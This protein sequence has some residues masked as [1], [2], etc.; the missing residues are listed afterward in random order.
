MKFK[1]LNLQDLQLQHTVDVSP[2]SGGVSGLVKIPV[3]NSRNNFNPGLSLQYSSSAKNSIFGMGWDIGGLSSISVDTKQG[4]PKYDGSDSFT[5]GGSKA[6]VPQLVENGSK[7]KERIEENGNYYIHF[8]RSKK[9]DLNIRFEKWIKKTDRTVHWRSRTKDNIL[10]IYGLDPT[11]K[12]KIYDTKNNNRIYSW[13]LE[14]QYDNLGNCILYYY[15]EEDDANVD[16]KLVF[17]SNRLKNFRNNGFTRRY[18]DKIVYGNTKPLVPDAAIPGTNKWLFELVFDY[19]QLKHRP[20]T[21]TQAEAGSSWDCRPDPYSVYTAGFEIRTYRLCK[22][23]LMYHHF[24]ELSVST[25]LTGIFECDFHEAETGTTLE[26]ISYTG[27]RRD[28]T[29]G[30]YSEKNLP[31]LT[32]NY[33]QPQLGQFFKGITKETNENLPQGFNHKHTKMVD[34]FGEGISGILTESSNNWYFKQ[35]LGNGE[36]SKQEIVISKPTQELKSASLGDFDN[37]GNLELFTLQGKMAGYYEYQRDKEEWSGFKSFENIPQ[38]GPSKLMDINAN[39]LS[40]LLVE[41]D[42]KITCYPFKGKEGFDKPYEFSKPVSN[43]KLYSPFVGNNLANDYFL[44]D[45]TGDGLSDQ[46]RISNGQVIYYPNLGN[47]HF[48]E[49]VIMENAPL[50]DFDNTYDT[51]RIRL[52]DLDGSGTNDI[53]YLGNGEIRYWYNASG[54]KFVNGGTIKGLPYIDNISESTILDLLGQGTPCL[55]WSNSLNNFQQNALQYLKITNGI[56]PR[57]LVSV[58]NGMGNEIQIEY[59]YSGQHYLEAKKSGNPWISKM[60]SHFTVADKKIVFD[61]ITN[62]KHIAQYKYKD[63]FYDSIERSFACFGLVEQYDSSFYENASITHEKDY[64]QP[65]CTKTWM[66]GGIFG[67]DAK[68][69]KQYY[70]ED[71]LQPMLSPVFFEQQDAINSREFAAGYQNM[72]GQVL[73]QEVYATSLEGIVALHPFMV[74]QSAYCI[75]KLQPENKRHKPAFFAFQTELLSINYDKNPADPL[76]CHQLSLNVNAFGDIEKELNIAYARRTTITD[77]LLQQ[78]TDYIKA[79][80]HSFTSIDT[81]DQYQSGILY[82]SKIFHI[83]HLAH[84]SNKIVSFSEAKASFESIVASAIDFDQD[85][86]SGGISVAKL[87]SWN[88]TFFW[89]N[90][91]NA[92][93]ALGQVENKTLVHHK[94]EA[95]FNNNFITNTFEGKVTPAML[96]DASEGGYVQKDGYWWKKTD[97]NIFLD[98]P[99][100]HVLDRIEK[101][102]GRT[103]RYAYDPYFLGATQITDP[104]DNVNRCEIDYNNLNPYR[105]IDINDNVSEV[106]YDPLGVAVVSFFQGSILD[107]HGTLQPYGVNPLNTY[108]KRNDESFN[109]I[110]TN[111]GLYLQKASSFIY[112]DLSCWETD[113]IPVRSINITREN[114]IHDGKGNVDTSDTIQ[115]E[116]NY[117]DGFGR[118]IQVKRKVEDGPAINRLIDGSVEVDISGEPVL[119]HS[120]NRWLASGH[121]VFNNKLKAIRNFEPF[122][123]NT[124]E[125]ESDTVLETFGVSSQLYY[126]AMG[127]VYRKDYPNSTF[128]EVEY[129][130]WQVISFDQNDT[131]DRSLYKVFREVLPGSSPERMALDKS[132]AHKETPTIINIDPLGREIFIN[133]QNNDGTSRKTESKYDILGNIVEITDSRDLKAFEY[134]YDMQ[135]RQLYE[136][137]MDAGEKWNFHNFLDQT[138]HL[139]DSRNIHQRISY[140][141]MERIISV[142]VDGA[143]GLNHITERF[144]YGEDASIM[145]AKERNLRG[146][147]VKH[148]DQAGTQE[149]TLAV[150]GGTSSKTERRL[151]NN[152]ASEANWNDPL[153]VALAPDIYRTEITYDARA[154]IVEQ[155]LPDQTTRK[156]IY[157]EGDSVQKILVS[158]A[159]GVLTDEEIMKD[160]SYDAKGLRQNVLLGN[161]IKTTY[162]Y[163][164]ESFRMKRLLTRSTGGS[165]RTY[166]DINYT[167]D[168]VGNLVHLVDEAQQPA[169][170]APGVIEG[171]NTS[172]HS[173]FTYDAL[174]QLK[175]ASGRVHQ[176]LLKNDYI[177]RSHESGAPANWAKGS[178]HIALNNGASVERYTRNYTYDES[179]N[180]LSIQHSGATHNW[181]R[182]NWTSAS[183][184]RSL[185]QL[186]LNGVAISNPENRFDNNGNCIYLPNLRSVE[187]NYRNNISKVVIIDRSAQDKANDEEFYIY[188]GDGIRIRKITQRVVDVANDTIELV[189]KIYLEGCEIKKIIRGGAEILNRYTSKISDGKN[190]LAVIHSWQTDIQARETDDVSQKNIH[191]Q[192]GNHL[193]SSS[194]ELDENGYVITYEEYFPFG[195]TSFLAGRNK[196]EIDLKTYRY[197]GKERDNFTGLYYFGY[198]YYAHWI[199]GWLSPDP[200]GPVD[201]ANLYV[202]AQNN[203]VNLI[204]PNGL[205]PTNPYDVIDEAFRRYNLRH[206]RTVTLDDGSIIESFVYRGQEVRNLS[207]V[208]DV[209]VVMH[210]RRYPNGD[211]PDL[212]IRVESQQREDLY[213]TWDIETNRP[214]IRRRE[215]SE[216]SRVITISPPPPRPPRLARP[217]RHSTPPPTPPPAPDPPPDA[218]QPETVTPPPPD[219]VEEPEPEPEVCEQEPEPEIPDLELPVSE[220]EPN[221]PVCE[222]DPDSPDAPLADSSE[223]TGE[224]HDANIPSHELPYAGS[225]LVSRNPSGFTLEVPNNFDPEKIA[226]YEDRI[227][228]DRGVGNRSAVPGERRSPRGSDVTDEIRYQNEGLLDDWVEAERAAGRTRPPGNHVDHGVELQ[229]IIRGNETGGADTVRFEDH[230]FQP[231]SV[232]TSQGS[233]ASHTRRR[234]VASGAPED[235]PAGGVARTDEMNLLRNSERLRTGLRLTGHIMNVGGPVL[236]FYGA[237]GIENPYV[238]YTAYG[239]ASVETYGVGLYYYGRIVLNGANGFEGGL[240]AMN[241]GSR[242]MRLGGGYGMIIVSGYSAVVHVQQGEYG[243][244]VGDGAGM[245]LG[246]MMITQTGSVPLIAITGTAMGA[247][248]LGDYVESRVTPEYGRGW[249]IAAGTGAG[250]GVGAVV[251]GGLVALG[252]VSNPVGWAILAVGGIAGLIGAIW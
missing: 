180:I 144:V 251:G 62:S 221:P 76:M 53:I 195:G 199:G 112:Y 227:L 94:E 89:N 56:K 177:D 125:F 71:V 123:S 93:L 78:K 3:T 107:D 32:F 39:G 154:R 69:A 84:D 222:M 8:Y 51:S 166:Q 230:R 250:L 236:V 159:D 80:V 65:S 174:Y 21:S 190:S 143:L 10:S 228:T 142:H 133:Q 208:H 169:S 37:D 57:L 203:P 186:E 64:A 17:E 45:M 242:F 47:G 13:L 217:P 27:V 108:S 147:L 135:S 33:T 183:S 173:E 18:P 246:Y 119:S 151:L 184:N 113:S 132:L 7:W 111:P 167:Y 155:K 23:I 90:N 73:R 129:S 66:H 126:D 202:Y 223:N 140:D 181:T 139:W 48:G 121:V 43:G 61:K 52:F 131:V 226:M 243:V 205:D 35:N 70:K 58:D 156:T 38:T 97:I 137:S 145:Q 187:W 115:L 172:S 100:F 157:N 178:R 158:T 233:S 238:R 224:G 83:N 54:N 14:A 216:S 201:S 149:T 81:K 28:L 163:D 146:I 87:I 212:N 234:A 34:L 16:S 1:P 122:F 49:Q 82:D 15:K 235:V 207:E 168:P 248:Y 5:Y 134:K 239:A 127:R 196:R 40:D 171:L 237:S 152:F 63:G 220:S 213:A 102:A 150:P 86:P 165:V 118:V 12:S 9:E 98:E 72:A 136:N 30:T 24:D 209:S 192:F 206:V 215:S 182:N 4:L 77:R 231:G 247:N 244:L 117:Q 191:Y 2:S 75:R 105:L 44:A 249:G 11:G 6:L 95:C 170:A 225:R 104:V 101:G 109:S 110:L 74:T 193:G 88:Q 161:D 240:A 252:L 229:H 31:S 218:S 211:P 91:L 92:E 26:K 103:A 198:R 162:T 214:I 99:A 42:D 124:H 29:S 25:S 96:S 55:V 41:N 106:L 148:Y 160:A 175:T 60:R 189:D 67:W 68:R 116:L 59:G 50:I 79:G 22:R 232:N 120:T 138:I 114:L 194:L 200:L 176:A 128:S 241:A 219:P 197:S 188:G 85:L 204:D 141:V 46:V 19:G 164:T 153:V 36:F 179:G 130:S 245:G 210:I 185:P 20:Y